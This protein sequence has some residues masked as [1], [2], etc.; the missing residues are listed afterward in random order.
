M[1]PPTIEFAA[2]TIIAKNYLSMARVLAESWNQFH[3]NSPLFV[4]LLDSPRGY[5][6]PELEPFKTVEITELGVPNLEGFL[7]K[8]AILEASTAVKPY[9][10]RYLFQTQ[11]I[12]KLLYLDPDIQLLS[13]L[14]TLRDYLDDYNILLTPHLTN[15]LPSD[16]Q[17]PTDH[18]IMQSGSYN[19][20]FLGLRNGEITRNLLDWWCE[21]LYHHCV[22]AIEKNLFVD[23]RWM[24]MVPGFYP[25]V[26]I[27][28]E[29]GYNIAYWNVHERHVEGNPGTYTVNGKPAYFFHYSGYDVD[30]PQKVSKHQ[31][32]YKRVS[33]LGETRH[34][35]ARYRQRVLANGWNETKNWKYDHNFFDNGVPIPHAARRY[36]WG[37]GPDVAH[38]GDPFTWLNDGGTGVS[39]AK[40]LRCP[41]KRPFGVNLM[42]YIHSEKGTGEAGRSNLRIVQ[43]ADLPFVVNNIV[44]P[45]SQNVE[46]LSLPISGDNPYAIN[47]ITINADQLPVF[48]RA[49]PPYLEGRYNIGFWAWELPE[50]PPMWASSFRYT[51]EIWVPSQFTR[52]AVAAASNL[53]VHVVPHSIDP[54]LNGTLRGDRKRF[55][56]KPGTFVFLFFFDFH[57][58]ME[59]KNPLGLI[60]AYKKAFGS[61]IDVELLIKTSHSGQYQ[62][63]LAML[64]KAAS[65]TNVRLMDCVL[66]REEKHQLMLAADSY[67][68]LHRS[69]G[70]GLTLAEAMLCGKP[71]IAT[72]YSGNMDFMTPETSFLIPAQVVTLDRN[73]GPY[74]AGCHWAQP[75]LNS[76]VDAMRQV[77]DNRE[78]ALEIGAKARHHVWETLHPNTIG[79]SVRQIVKN[80]AMQA[81]PVLQRA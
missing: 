70:F 55:G 57:S 48:A 15:P 19:L 50:F 30:E 7:F 25:G 59:R 68:S 75:D 72:A 34:L 73:Y 52:D 37:L 69:E 38:L 35:Y 64:Q 22:V 4:L 40:S 21:K 71:V 46:K 32:R 27:C 43:A 77:V 6:D 62:K 47:L 78:T 20:G 45:E 58:I 1:N 24:D 13:S 63:E 12:Q 31:T 74:Q 33:D 8:Y 18:S 36:Y 76:A 54:T 16:G 79:M 11:G 61:R 60:E 3:P 56:M 28:R 51:D 81:E 17:H 29:P 26:R 53:P 49:H 2:C 5:F 80:I 67:I 41:P 44:S 23:Q 39:K 42:G 10:L 14:S 65:G 9:L 66:S